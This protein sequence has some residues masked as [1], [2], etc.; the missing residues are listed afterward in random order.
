MSLRG[1]KFQ[2]LKEVQC[3]QTVVAF[4][5]SDSDYSSDMHTAEHLQHT[6]SFT[7]ANVADIDRRP[8]GDPPHSTQLPVLTAVAQFGCTGTDSLLQRERFTDT[9]LQKGCASLL[10]S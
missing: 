10:N 3:L 7:V 6:D 5:H 8:T 2:P 9:V 1:H 4:Q